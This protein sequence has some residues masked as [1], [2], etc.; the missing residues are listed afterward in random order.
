MLNCLKNLSVFT[1]PITGQRMR[2]NYAALNV[3]EFGSVYEGL[4]E[5]DPR[6]LDVDGRMEFSFVAGDDRAS[7]GSHYTPDELVQP[8]IKHSLDY[9]IADRL[10]SAKTS[11]SNIILSDI[12]L[13][14]PKSGQNDRGQ[15]DSYVRRAEQA[16]LSI[17][18]CDVACGSGHILLNAARRIA[19]ELAILRTGEDQPSPT[20]FRAAVR[21][22]IRNCIYGV[23]LNPLA[24]ELC[25]VGLWLEAHVPGEPLNFLDHHIKCGNAIVGL[26]SREELQRGIPDEAFKTL[27][28]DD[29][30]VAAELRKQN[31]EERKGYQSLDFFGRPAN[32]LDALRSDFSSVAELPE[33]TPEEIRQ[34][35]AAYDEFR[36]GIHLRNLKTLADV[37]VAQFYIPKTPEMRR[38]LTTHDQYRRYLRG[39]DPHPEPT[40]YAQAVAQRKRFFHWFLEFPD[41]FANGDIWP[42]LATSTTWGYGPTG[43]FG[44]GFPTIR[45]RHHDMAHSDFFSKDFVERFWRPWVHEGRDVESEFEAT[46][47]PA[48][49]WMSLLTLLPLK[50]LFVTII[51]VLGGWLGYQF[52]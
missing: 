19:T 52:L 2:V 41:I 30:T 44:F 36:R 35:Q 37:Q 5:Y 3:E 27:P 50:Y 38:K 7:S 10:E 4:L 26:A 13:T 42:V 24:V 16:L 28:D 48:P 21:D 17:T 40:A 29:K 22:V 11:S 43:T 6:I 45:D 9:I 8:L 51:L 39:E 46:Q 12:I 34:K 25:K 47:P 31:K 33:N 18:V 1:N 23:D 14:N 15:N 32:D 49:L 20:A